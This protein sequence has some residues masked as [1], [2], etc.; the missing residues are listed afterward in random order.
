MVMMMMMMTNDNDNDSTDGDDEALQFGSVHL[1][2]R[3]CEP[4]SS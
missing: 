3:V 4:Q 1:C 2:F